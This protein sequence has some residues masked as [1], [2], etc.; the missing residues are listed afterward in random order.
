MKFYDLYVNKMVGK[1]DIHKFI[2]EWH[3][4]DFGFNYE[5]YNFLGMTKEQYCK[6]VDTNEIEIV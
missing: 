6:W 1:E 5:L 3:N 4:T 2:E